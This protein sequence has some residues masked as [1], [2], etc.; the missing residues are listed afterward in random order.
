MLLTNKCSPFWYGTTNAIL[1]Y[2]TSFHD[3]I[4]SGKVRIYRQNVSHLSHQE[5]H[6]ED[7][8]S[9]DVQALV[10]ATGY[11]LAPSVKF[12]PE[13][14]HAD[15]GI[16]SRCLSGA[17]LDSWADLDE[18]ADARVLEE[19]PSLASGPGTSSSLSSIPSNPQSRMSPKKITDVDQPYSPY[20]LYRS[21]APPGL[22]VRGDR[23]I[24]FIGYFGNIAAT[25][26]LEI[27]SLWAYAYLSGKLKID[28]STVYKET[29]LFTRWNHWR[30]PYG[31]GRLYPDIVFDQNPF[32]D[33]LLQD[34]GLPYWRKSNILSELF[35]SYSQVDYKGLTQEWLRKVE[36]E[37]QC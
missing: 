14:T 29:A 25:A 22:T 30:S 19:C 2:P 34:L 13:D 9:L 6:L 28:T 5:V 16:P 10:T 4:K 18:E 37:K 11:S 8:T 7:R 12:L 26:R 27:T 23:S 20:R 24:V 32:F 31:H 36:K 33:M 15:L 21:I 35:E 3:L 1:N 17:Q